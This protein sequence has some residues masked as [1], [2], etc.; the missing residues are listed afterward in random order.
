MVFKRLRNLTPR[1]TGRDLSPANG[2]AIHV[3]AVAL[4]GATAGPTPVLRPAA[5][6]HQVLFDPAE[7]SPIWARPR[8]A[9]APVAASAS[10]PTVEEPAVVGVAPS[11]GPKPAKRTRRP[12]AKAPETASAPKRSKKTA[13]PDRGT[14]AG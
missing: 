8:A 9:S 10:A 11:D 13:K 1:R 7:L 12:A 2:P 4:E 5:I 14:T 6:F 3:G